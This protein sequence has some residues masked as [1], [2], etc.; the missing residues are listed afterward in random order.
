MSAQPFKVGFRKCTS[1]TCDAPVH[2]KRTTCSTCGA[3]QA[4]DVKPPTTHDIEP[5]L[6]GA[7]EA[8]RVVS[9]M[10]DAVAAGP[11]DIPDV[12]HVVAADCRPQLDN[13]M[14]VLKRGQVITDYDTIRRLIA[15]GAPLVPENAAHGLACC[16]RCQTVFAPAPFAP[17][18]RRQAG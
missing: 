18:G 4:R 13:V 6:A 5:P 7:T 14:A 11:R 2:Y 1:A 12:P 9:I 10:T 17:Q 3:I 8:P 16:P 15:V